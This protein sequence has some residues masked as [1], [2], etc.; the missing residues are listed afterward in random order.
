LKQDI[1]SNYNINPIQIFFKLDLNNVGN[2]SKSDF[3]SFLNF[4][5]I[6]FSQLDIDYI[7][8]FYDKDEDNL[9]CFNEFL[10]LIISDSN[11]FYKKSYRKKYRKKRF[12]MEELNGDVDPC[13]EKQILEILL[14]EIE[15]SRHLIDLIMNIKQNNDFVIQN[16]FYEI[17]SYSYITN[18][19][20]KAF[21]DRNEVDYNDKFIKNIFN[22]LSLKDTVGKICFNKFKNFFDLPFNKNLMNKTSQMIENQVPPNLC[23]TFISSD[24]KYSGTNLNNKFMCSNNTNF[25]I[26]TQ[27]N[28]NYCYN[29]LRNEK[30]INEEDIQFECSHLSRSGS[31]E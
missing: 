30:Y 31:I 18:D 20:L 6:N 1:L 3:S 26:N 17:K 15:L 14:E 7:F 8:Y 11:Y 23:Q 2:L 25:D 22:R 28:N 16:V 19:S 21:F 13:I 4:F 9:L 24:I 5:S 29:N 27:Y 10:D 12:D